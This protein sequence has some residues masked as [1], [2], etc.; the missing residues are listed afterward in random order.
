MNAANSASSRATAEPAARY[1][2][3]SPVASSAS[4]SARAAAGIG[5]AS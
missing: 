2:N 1:R 3:R 5:S 4:T